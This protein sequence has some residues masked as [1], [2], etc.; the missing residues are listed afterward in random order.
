MGLDKDREKLNKHTQGRALMKTIVWWVG[1]TLVG[2]A[3]HWIHSCAYVGPRSPDTV[4]KC[5]QASGRAGGLGQA[6]PNQSLRRIL[7]EVGRK[8]GI[9]LEALAPTKGRVVVDERGTGT[10]VAS[11]VSESTFCPTPHIVPPDTCKGLAQPVIPLTTKVSFS[12]FLMMAMGRRQ[13]GT[14]TVECWFFVLSVI[15]LR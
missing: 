2:G 12:L 3:R 9:P 13:L 7:R 8:W 4:G 1:C 10:C 15:G 6:T 14:V 11:R 5:G